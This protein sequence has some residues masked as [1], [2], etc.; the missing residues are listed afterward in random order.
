V[1]WLNYG[2]LTGALALFIVSKFFGG[3]QSELAGL[4]IYGTL[5]FFGPIIVMGF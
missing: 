3:D 2:V 5:S 4:I 1:D